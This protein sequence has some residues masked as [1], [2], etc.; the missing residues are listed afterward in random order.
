MTDD[1][2]RPQRDLIEKMVQ[3]SVARLVSRPDAVNGDLRLPDIHRTAEIARKEIDEWSRTQPR[4][5][6]IH[7]YWQGM[8]ASGGIV[9]ILFL[10]L[11]DRAVLKTGL[12]QNALHSLAGTDERIEE[13]LNSP[14]SQGLEPVPMRVNRWTSTAL[15]EMATQRDAGLVAAVRE[16]LAVQPVQVFQGQAILGS[17]VPVQVRNEACSELTFELEGWRA[18]TDAI[19]IEALTSL[20]CGTQAQITRDGALR[21]P[22]WARFHNSPG[23]P[24]DQVR[25]LIHAIEHRQQPSASAA[26]HAVDRSSAVHAALSGL[27][28]DY[29]PSN[30]Q[31]IRNR[32]GAEQID[33]GWVID[34]RKA[35]QDEGNSFWYAQIDNLI[36]EV[37]L[38]PVDSR[39]LAHDLIHTLTLS[40]DDLEA[41]S[42][43]QEFW[44]HDPLSEEKLK[45]RCDVTYVVTM[46][47]LVNVV[48]ADAR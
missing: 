1:F 43:C 44:L 28:F 10:A 42:D 4:W 35:L 3:D 31:R 41:E 46:F 26:N 48:R 30:P 45:A 34:L 11:M 19:P 18:A 25:V 20:A 8:V 47:V 9:L 32:N 6:Q 21:V 17:T 29:E 37:S 5:W 15:S 36:S 27:R 12:L 24:R 13:H 14:P 16:I 33:G 40:I 22:F 38:P 2:T 23:K 39:P 7:K